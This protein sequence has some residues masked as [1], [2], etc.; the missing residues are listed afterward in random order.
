[1]K[2]TMPT[3]MKNN[4]DN[5]YCGNDG[6]NDNIEKRKIIVVMMMVIVIT[7]N[8]RI[9]DF[10]NLLIKPPA[11]SNTHAHVTIQHYEKDV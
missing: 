2:T 5:G 3:I 10:C 1:M 11:D 4:N 8:A 6:N 7:L 9:L